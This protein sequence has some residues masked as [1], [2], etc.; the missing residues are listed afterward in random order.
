MGRKALSPTESFVYKTWT[1]TFYTKNTKN[2]SRMAF[3]P[4]ELKSCFKETFNSNEKIIYRVNCLEESTT[5]P[6]FNA[7]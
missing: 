4:F 7:K 2:N 1:I 3:N 5:I 6:Y